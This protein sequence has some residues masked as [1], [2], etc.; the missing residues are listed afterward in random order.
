MG[1]RRIVF[2]ASIALI[3]FLS[4]CG[5]RAQTN[6]VTDSDVRPSALDSSLGPVSADTGGR[7]APEDITL[8]VNDDGTYHTITLRSSSG[9][10]ASLVQRGPL[11]LVMPDQ[12]S[13]YTLQIS[14][15]KDAGTLEGPASAPSDRG[16]DPGR[17]ADASIRRERP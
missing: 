12:I 4:G 7:G 5:K 13:G 9:R 6:A 10:W 14:V 8:T 11:Y 2:V 3:A 1:K 17:A 16:E 15:A